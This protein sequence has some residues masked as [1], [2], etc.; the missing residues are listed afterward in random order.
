MIL[1]K[2]YTEE[3]LDKLDWNYAYNGDPNDIIYRLHSSLVFF[4]L[5]SPL[6]VV[7]LLISFGIIHD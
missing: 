6:L 1:R 7:L 2:K 4:L 5:I 3:E